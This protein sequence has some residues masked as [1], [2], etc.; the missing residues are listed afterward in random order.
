MS[1]MDT[2]SMKLITV[3]DS[4]RGQKKV[5]FI[6]INYNLKQNACTAPE[7]IKVKTEAKSA[8]CHSSLL[9]QSSQIKKGNYG[10]KNKK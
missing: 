9:F 2:T 4:I 10:N 5:A 1:F 6:C 7:I 8:S 3:K